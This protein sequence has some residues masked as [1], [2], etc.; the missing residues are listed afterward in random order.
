MNEFDIQFKIFT[1]VDTTKSYFILNGSITLTLSVCLI[2]C[3]DVIRILR[4]F[5]QRSNRQT[6]LYILQDR[7]RQ[8]LQKTNIQRSS[9]GTKLF[10]GY[11][12]KITI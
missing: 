6:C 1:L 3:F 8:K 11:K 4:S 9:N 2:Y 12:R 10:D 7:I 5:F